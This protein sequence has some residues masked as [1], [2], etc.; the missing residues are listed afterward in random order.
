MSPRAQMGQ[1][2]LSRR[3]L[4]LQL[5]DFQVPELDAVAFGLDADVALGQ[6]AV[7]EL[8]GDSAID[9]EGDGFAFGGDFHGI[10]IAGLLDAVL[11]GVGAE[12]F[13]LSLV[14]GGLA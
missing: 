11:G 13:F 6:S 9:P 2:I 5:F 4:L 7:V 12:S 10:P 14:G 3:E 1:E 8:G